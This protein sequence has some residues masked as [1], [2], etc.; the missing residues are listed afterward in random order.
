MQPQG[1]LD[2]LPQEF[3]AFLQLFQIPVQIFQQIDLDKQFRYVRA[4][5]VTLQEVEASFGGAKVEEVPL[6]AALYKVDKKN[7]LN[8]NALYK[9]G[10]L[11]GID[12]G[13]AFAVQA[14]GIDTQQDHL[15]VLDM[16]C[17]PGA[18]FC[19]IADLLKSC[20]KSFCLTGV[21]VSKDRLNICRSLCKKY[22]H[23]S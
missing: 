20:C 21:D 16:C 22:G 6:V 17:A 15:Q 12:L 9:S 11:Y 10:H 4:R 18:K 3:L 2:V 13:S 8:N 7:N 5:G 23:V 1:L 14:L 19:F